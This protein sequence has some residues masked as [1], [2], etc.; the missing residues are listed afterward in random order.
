[1][2]SHI[3]NHI[4]REMSRRFEWNWKAPILGTKHK[5]Q[6]TLTNVNQKHFPFFYV[7]NR[8][9]LSLTF[10][11]NGCI[12]P[13]T[14]VSSYLFVLSIYFQLVRISATL[15]WNFCRQ[16]NVTEKLQWRKINFLG[17]F[18]SFARSFVSLLTS[19]KHYIILYYISG[20]KNTL[21]V[22]KLY[23]S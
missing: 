1:M 13:M 4:S 6:I 21:K 22:W 7:V 3:L 16:Q 15:K 23:V 9:S 19:L 14:V 17:P 5:D 8:S 12:L 10:S 20:K 11:C 18:S 2:Y